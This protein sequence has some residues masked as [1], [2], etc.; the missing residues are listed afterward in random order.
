LPQPAAGGAARAAARLRADR[1]LDLLGACARI[2]RLVH[3]VSLSLRRP[4]DPR[5]A[6]AAAGE[7]SRA[8]GR[9]TM[10]IAALLLFSVAFADEL[11]GEIEVKD[12]QPVRSSRMELA[13]TQGLA[14]LLTWAQDAFCHPILVPPSE[15]ARSMIIDVPSGEVSAAEQQRL[16]RAAIERSGL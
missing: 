16:F 3:L 2:R 5:R 6:A 9:V 13:P 12:C 11:P 7:R 15:L 1:Q 4:A 8:R 10:R 14:S